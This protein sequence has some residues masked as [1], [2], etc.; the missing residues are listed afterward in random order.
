MT[1]SA[2]I[3]NLRFSGD[4][5]YVSRVCTLPAFDAPKGLP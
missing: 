4:R 5:P 3:P 1:V 2:C